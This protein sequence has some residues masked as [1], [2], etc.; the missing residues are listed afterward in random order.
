MKK[1]GSKLAAKT[2]KVGILSDKPH[3]EGG[4]GMVELAAI[5]E[6]GSPTNNIPARS[7]IASPFKRGDTQSEQ[8]KISAKIA[9]GIIDN[10]IG[11][12]AGLEILG[13]WG[14]AT[15]KKNIKDGNITPDIKQATKDRKKSTEPLVDNGHLI[16]AIT[17]K[18]GK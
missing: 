3:P 11:I 13:A 6:F 16:N 17:H 14:T 15:I 9:S 12:D 10:K 18:V 4:V 1:L 5:H 8:A 2:V 7:F